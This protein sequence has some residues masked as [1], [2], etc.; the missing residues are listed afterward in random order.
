MNDQQKAFMIHVALG[1]LDAVRE[2]EEPKSARY[3]RVDKAED[4]IL[5]LIEIYRPLAW[6]TEMMVRAGNL[7]DEFNVRIAQEFG[8]VDKIQP[9]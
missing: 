8:E 3:K 4:R 9:Q 7:V 6:P 2:S 5:E 1:A